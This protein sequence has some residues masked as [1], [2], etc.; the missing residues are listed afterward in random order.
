[1]HLYI[2]RAMPMNPK[3]SMPLDNGSRGRKLYTI[4]P[5]FPWS[6][7]I[8]ESSKHGQFATNHEVQ[9]YGTPVREFMDKILTSHGENSLLYVSHLVP[10]FSRHP[11]HADNEAG[12]FRYHS[13][14]CGGQRATM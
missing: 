5:I 12:R 7:T 2:I 14:V 10:T 3:R 13:E 1:M 4:G 8:L 6:G 9:E 11:Y